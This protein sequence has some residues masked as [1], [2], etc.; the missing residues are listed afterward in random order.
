M[1]LPHWMEGLPHPKEKAGRFVG[2]CKKARKCARMPDNGGNRGP[3]YEALAHF[4]K[5]HRKACIDC[6]R[7]NLSLHCCWLH[8][9]R[10]PKMILKANHLQLSLYLIALQHIA[11][12][13]SRRHL[14]LL[15]HLLLRRWV[16]SALRCFPLLMCPAASLYLIL[17]QGSSVL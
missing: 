6:T 12:M 7:N 8:E 14:R 3:S 1:D 10:I 11:H 9:Q 17:C 2:H 5:L 13:S 4:K 15:L 16:T